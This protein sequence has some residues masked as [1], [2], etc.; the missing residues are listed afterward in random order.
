MG[1]DALGRLILDTDAAGG[2]QSLVRTD[3]SH[4][5]EVARTTGLHRTTRYRVE[6][7]PSGEQH[8]VDTF[9]DGTQSDTL[10]G[11][12]GSRKT[13]LSDGTLFTLQ[14]GPDPRWGMQA[15]I[16]KHETITTPGGL[17]WTATVARTANLADPTNL[18][19]LITQTDT[20]T[21]NNRTYT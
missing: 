12:D 17:V 7:L 13:A 10:I 4:G 6:R 2:S 11:T 15:P 8:R 19:S 9:P 14:Q 21:I 3:L 20:A 16:N 1:Y 18:L 5:Y